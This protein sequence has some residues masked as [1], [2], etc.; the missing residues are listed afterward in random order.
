MLART[1]RW[2]GSHE[3]KYVD[4]ELGTRKLNFR[5]LRG[6][7]KTII[8]RKRQIYREV[9]TGKPRVLIIRQPGRLLCYGGKP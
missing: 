2:E 9:E 5:I 7:Y 1:L 8:S 4:W 6:N 3:T